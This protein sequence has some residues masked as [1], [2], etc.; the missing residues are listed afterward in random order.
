MRK[1]SAP[2]AL[3]ATLLAAATAT[4]GPQTVQ[5]QGRLTDSNG[6]PVDGVVPRLVFRLYSTATPTPMG[7]VWGEVHENVPAVRGVFSVQLGAGT[8]TVDA[9]G[10]E[11]AGPNPLDVEFDGGP[12]WLE[13]S[14]ALLPATPATPV[15]PPTPVA[16]VPFALRAESATQADS[17]TTALH[18][19]GA[20]VSSALTNPAAPT[21]PGLTITDLDTRYVR[22]TGGGGN[23]VRSLNGQ[24]ND[25]SIVA[26]TNVTLTSGPGTITINSTGGGLDLATADARYFNVSGDVAAQVNVNGPIFADT[27]SA[28]ELRGVL[29]AGGFRWGVANAITTQ[30]GQIGG[31]LLFRNF[32]GSYTNCGIATQQF[33]AID[34]FIGPRVVATTSIQA[35]VKN[36]VVPHP[37]DPTKEI[38]YTCIEGPEAGMYCRG[39]ATLVNGQA[40]IDLPEHFAAMAAAGTLTVQLTPI[41][42]CRGLF[43]V[44]KAPGQVVVREC[45]GGTSGVTFDYFVSARR[46]GFDAPVV[47]ARQTP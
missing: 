6:Q 21:G 36:F 33:N 9:A 28:N 39:S 40:T 42:D 31:S 22:T 38:V 1:H 2:L 7:F 8:R 15:A 10:V 30:Q 47:R 12:R 20:A 24:V 29:V 34:L 46:A 27:V 18:A 14:V 41:G 11:T 43:V 19:D 37:N 16:S 44:S 17:A 32:D 13:T 26:G 5:F 45:Q 4:A 23:V 25:V 35:P 3:L